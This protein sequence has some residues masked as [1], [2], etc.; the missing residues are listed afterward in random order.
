MNENETEPETNK[1]E[2]YAEEE[3]DFPGLGV[4]EEDSSAATEV[5]TVR[6]TRSIKGLVKP[7]QDAICASSPSV[8]EENK[9]PEPVK[10]E[11]KQRKIRGLVKPDGG[12]TPPF[13]KGVV[14]SGKQKHE[15]G[16]KHGTSNEVDAVD[17]INN[18]HK[19]HA[20]AT[21]APD[22]SHSNGAGE[23]KEPMTETEKKSSECE[24]GE[25]GGEER[26]RTTSERGSVASSSGS[27][28][29]TRS[30]A[31]AQ[32][33]EEPNDS[34]MIARM[35]R[36]QKE[37]EEKCTFSPALNPKSLQMAEGRE[38][39][40]LYFIDKPKGEENQENINHSPGIKEAARK[41]QE[42]L[43]KLEAEME[44]KNAKM[45]QSFSIN[46]RSEELSNRR[47]AEGDVFTRLSAVDVEK[48]KKK[49][50]EMKSGQESLLSSSPGV[51]VLPKSKELAMRR[52]EQGDVITRLSKVDLDV[53][54]SK[55]HQLKEQLS[56]EEATSLVLFFI[57][58]TRGNH[59]RQ[60]NSARGRGG[61]D[62]KSS[63]PKSAGGE[64][65]NF[66]ERSMKYLEK[67][68][69]ALEVPQ[70]LKRQRRLKAV[71][72][73][74]R[75][76]KEEEE[77]KILSARPKMNDTSRELASSRSSVLSQTGR[78]ST[79][80][81]PEQGKGGKASPSAAKGKEVKREV[82]GGGEKREERKE[83]RKEGGNALSEEKDVQLKKEL[84]QLRTKIESLEKENQ[85]L[86][87]E[88]SKK[89]E[90]ILKLEQDLQQHRKEKV[91]AE[92]KRKKDE[93][94]VKEGREADEGER[95]EKEEE[96]EG[97][98]EHLDAD[99]VKLH[100]K[101][102]L[103][104][105][106]RLLSSEFDHDDSFLFANAALSS[107]YTPFILYPLTHASASSFRTFIA[108]PLCS[109]PLSGFDV[110][111]PQAV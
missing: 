87:A 60:V 71:C 97:S 26:K 22:G 79:D 89:G 74:K 105:A 16:R 36:E 37:R 2:R 17:G 48:K 63:R 39:K 43:R 90:Q 50:Q 64:G 101:E 45:I 68:K 55:I 86:K 4:A 80:A 11:Q 31:N 61:A 69:A 27:R 106:M 33:E 18:E 21:D 3:Q 108:S 77:S 14:G 51:S 1:D 82:E 110:K 109:L 47:V 12:E 91:E 78:R 72:Q 13:I 30:G 67:K 98:Q 59:R 93:G 9:H 35:Q 54:W 20:Q 81:Q 65:E 111:F 42:E 56:L 75:L 57:A 7:N 25:E 85:A 29:E 103:R 73:E 88:A 5:D 83:A 107:L 102:C 94:E 99:R 28:N 49:L 19:D 34:V 66:F 10:V 92:A 15:K 58:A 76:Q 84:H 23:K 53:K 96:Q 38:R 52:S 46:R 32:A 40:P 8:P 95:K 70:S 44:E 62:R 41:H 6:P 24:E 100:A 104:V